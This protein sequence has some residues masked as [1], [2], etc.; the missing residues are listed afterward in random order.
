MSKVVSQNIKD[1]V[2]S[3]APAEY[4]K[5]SDLDKLPIF[6]KSHDPRFGDINLLQDAKNK[7]FIAVQEHKFNDLKSVGAWIVE[8]KD[9]VKLNHP[10]L[11]NLKDYS[12][13]KQSELCS[14]FYILKLFFEY[15]KS[16]LKKE[17]NERKTRGERF[18]IDE[19]NNIYN[20]QNSA[21]SYLIEHGK[22]HGDVQPLQ[23]GYNKDR[24]ETKLIQ[25]LELSSADAVRANLK[26]K[27]VKNDVVF[28][29]PKT[30]ESLANGK[31]NA[32]LNPSQEDHYNLGLSVLELANQRSV[33]D[34]YNKGN[35]AVDQ[36]ALQAHVQG[37]TQNYGGSAS[38]LTGNIMNVNNSISN[39]QSVHQ[40]ITTVVDGGH[41]HTIVKTRDTLT[42]EGVGLYDG[43]NQNQTQQTNVVIQN[44][45]PERKVQSSIPSD[46]HIYSEPNIGDKDSQ[47]KKLVNADEL[48]TNDRSPHDD[49]L[50]YH[51]SQ[52]FDQNNVVYTQYQNPNYAHTVY[53]TAPTSY[54]SNDRVVYSSPQNVTFVNSEIP[55][56]EGK[57]VYSSYPQYTHTVVNSSSP[58]QSDVPYSYTQQPAQVYT[59]IQNHVSDEDLSGLKLVRTYQDASLATQKKNY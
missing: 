3:F 44:H 46:Y 28:C 27:F 37:L 18:G 24:G 43:I 45:V 42:V 35:K 57:V 49:L 31:A 47:K 34:I 26:N 52:Q 5:K 59:T 33:S 55:R 1:A 7:E 17:S 19:L 32:E 8:A 36:Q 9:R 14:T 39:N 12:V 30:F 15:P 51:G 56:E 58:S 29:T 21:L 6:K 13:T 10:N 50:L 54:V 2:A 48:L 53:S 41:I 20:Q 22:F 4:E 25:K 11:A 38:E 16:D 40:H 23:I